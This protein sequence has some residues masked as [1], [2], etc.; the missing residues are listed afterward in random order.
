MTRHVWTDHCHRSG[1]H[2]TPAWR[3]RLR[4]ERGRSELLCPHHAAQ[5]AFYGHGVLTPIEAADCRYEAH[6]PGIAVNKLRWE[7]AV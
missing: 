6:S 2:H 5:A 7:I 4:T 1:C 3:L